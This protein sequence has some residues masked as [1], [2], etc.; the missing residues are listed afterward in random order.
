MPDGSLPNSTRLLQVKI[1]CHSW[2]K[3]NFFFFLQDAGPLPP[4]TLTMQFNSE[5]QKALPPVWLVDKTKY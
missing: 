5:M 1:V 2:V 4:Y 3:V